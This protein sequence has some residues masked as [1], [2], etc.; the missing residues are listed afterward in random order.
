[1]SFI[2]EEDDEFDR[3]PD[4]ILRLIFNKLHDA[5]SLSRCNLVCK[6]F[7]SLIPQVDNVYLTVPR[8]S[9]CGSYDQISKSSCIDCSHRS[10]SLFKSLIRKLITT[11]FRC[12]RRIITLKSSSSSR[13]DCSYHSP[14]E[15]LKNFKEIQSL[16]IELPGYGGE[17]ES[18]NDGDSLLRWR[19]EFG[20]HLESCVILGS[21]SF[22][23]QNHKQQQEEEDEEEAELTDDELKLRVVWTISC[24]IAASARHYLMQQ[25]VSTHQMLQNVVVTDRSKQGRL[26]MKREQIEEL[27]SKVN[28]SAELELSPMLERT[29]LPALKMKLWY[30]P[31]IE[32]PASG[33]VMRGATLLVIRPV[34]GEKKVEES[35]GDL[36]E[37]VWNGE[38]GGGEEEV[39]SEAVWEMMKKK[40]SYTLEMNSF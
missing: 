23:T 40:K 14:N 26:N 9:L 20:S 3:L 21:K 1:M 15:I 16:Q 32:L 17:I 28:S 27:R 36:V 4:A 24:L 6:R 2:N 25:V 35:D 33:C 37:R 11:P 29:P 34:D 22:D 13:F 31:V 7:A 10:K 39:F 38:G 30:V 19:A 12:L 5:E 18:I 8:K